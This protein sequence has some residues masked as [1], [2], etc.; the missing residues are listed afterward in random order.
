MHQGDIPPTDRL[1]TVSEAAEA[2]LGRSVTARSAL[3][4]AIHGRSGVRLPTVRGIRGQRCCTVATF[5][6]WLVASSGDDVTA[7]DATSRTDPAADAGLRAL[8]VRR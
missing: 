4:W 8:G 6:A 3:R 2:V 1:M 7:T 5:R